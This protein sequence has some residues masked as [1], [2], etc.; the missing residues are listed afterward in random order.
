ML[1]KFIDASGTKSV[2]YVVYSNL[3]TKGYIK[4]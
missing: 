2:T 1:L 3:L 4:K